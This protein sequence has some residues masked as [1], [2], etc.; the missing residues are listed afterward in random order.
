VYLLAGLLNDVKVAVVALGLI[1]FVAGVLY[2]E[3]RFMR[4]RR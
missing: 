4:R 3:L 2:L 1:A